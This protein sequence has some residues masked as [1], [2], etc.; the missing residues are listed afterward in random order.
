MPA[1]AA[2]AAQ[3]AARLRIV[4]LL[5][6]F[7]LIISNVP[8]PNTQLFL[9]GT[10]LLATYPVSAITDGQGLNITLL[11]YLG[12]LHFGVLACRELVPDVDKLVDYLVAELETLCKLASQSTTT[13]AVH[14]G[15]SS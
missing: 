5:N 3:L 15:A 1:V 4:E 10:P 2:R 12:Q 9:A 14:S 6:P 11:G 7:N 8:G 13:D